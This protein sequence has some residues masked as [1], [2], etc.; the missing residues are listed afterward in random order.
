MA[1]TRERFESGMTY[2]E[3]KARMTRNKERLG[4]ADVR[5]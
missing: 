1:V 4:A 3:W 5:H 2:D